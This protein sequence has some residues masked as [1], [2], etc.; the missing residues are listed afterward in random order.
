MISALPT[1]PSRQ[2]PTNFNDRADA[3]LGALPQFQ[4][5]A[6]TL[7]TDVNANQLAANYSA[8]LAAASELAAANTAG[9]T[10]WTSG[11]YA[12]GVNK[13][14]PSNF[15][16][17]RRKIAGASSVDPASDPS[18]WQLL[19]GLGNTTLQAV[20]PVGSIYINAGVTTNP[21]TL[22][23]FGTWVA[24]GAGRVMIGLDGSDTL[25]DTL[26]ESGGSKD[27]VVVSHTHNATSTVTDPGHSHS[28][29][30]GSSFSGN[31]YV[32]PTVN[33]I[34]L[35][36]TTGAATTGISV[37]TTVASTGSSGTNANLQP[38][39]TVCMWQRTA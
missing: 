35:N 37:A 32:Q 1:P 14:S 11:T 30:L 6:N 7:Q 27:A 24:F 25:F 36:V 10:L 21:A 22:F 34:G 38:Y 2:D 9:A 8:T 15:L 33:S 31:V 13:F 19:T 39:I 3:F 26:G 29:G 28:V 17:Y 16:T 5:E 18:G 12:V 4:S 23:G 20:Y